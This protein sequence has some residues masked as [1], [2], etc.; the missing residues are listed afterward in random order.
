VCRLCLEEREQ[1][2]DR[3]GDVCCDDIFNRVWRGALV[4]VCGR[5]CSMRELWRRLHFFFE[6]L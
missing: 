1:L 3:G 4:G 6:G 2:A 5:G